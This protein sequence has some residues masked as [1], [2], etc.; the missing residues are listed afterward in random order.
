[1]STGTE[2]II[3]YIVSD[4]DHISYCLGRKLQL[5]R[6]ERDPIMLDLKWEVSVYT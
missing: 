3:Q 1:M 2:Q 5:R 4:G 6:G